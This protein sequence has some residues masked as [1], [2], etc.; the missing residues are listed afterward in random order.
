MAIHAYIP[1][2]FSPFSP[3]LASVPPSFLL[4]PGIG[5]STFHRSYNIGAQPSKNNN[6]NNNNKSNKKK[7]GRL[8][9][10]FLLRCIPSAG[11]RRT[12]PNTIL[13]W[14]TWDFNKILFAFFRVWMLH[15]SL[16]YVNVCKCVFY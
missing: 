11:T 8:E 12:T 10:L 4:L 9:K 14:H 15:L 3:H 2:P 1:L 13:T 5:H 16:L 6:D 7:R